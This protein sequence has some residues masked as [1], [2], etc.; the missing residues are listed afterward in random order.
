MVAEAPDR[1]RG[2]RAGHQVRYP[3]GRF[4]R[5]ISVPGWYGRPGEYRTTRG[6]GMTIRVCV[7]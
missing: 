7:P 3:K 6:P 1:I 4:P 5:S 2:W